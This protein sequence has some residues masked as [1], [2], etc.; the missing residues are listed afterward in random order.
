VDWSYNLLPPEEQS[1]LRRL[2]VFL[3]GWTLEAAE[4]I[5]GDE[6]SS[7]VVASD[8]VLDNLE[9]LINK[10]LVIT[11]DEHGTSRYRMLETIRQYANEK[12]V[13]SGESDALHDKHLEYFLNL[14]ETAA[15]HLIRH[16]QLEW[17]AQLDADYENLRAALEWALG[18]DA[19]ASSLRLCAALGR[20]WY[21]RTILLE[22]SKWLKSALS[23]T[24]P[25]P[26]QAEKVAR[27]K[28][29]YED[30][31][32]AEQLDDLERQKTSAE[33]SFALAREVSG[34]RDNVIARYE[35]AYVLYR[36]GEYEKALPLLEQSLTEFQELNELYWELQSYRLLSDILVDHGELKSTEKT[37][38]DLELAR[39][40]GERL[41]F[42]N[43]LLNYSYMLFDF[44][45]IDEARGYA[46]EA[47]ILFHQIGSN[48]SSTSFLFA[49]IARVN[50]DYEEAKSFYIEMKERFGLLG[51]KSLR[52][53]M[54]L[55]LGF[56]ALEQG[57]LDPAHAYF[58]EALTTSREL[59]YKPHIPIIAACLAGLGN[60][61]YLQGNI[62]KFKGSYRESVFLA[63]ELR[64]H[65]KIHIVVSILQ[66]IYSQLPENSA[67][68]LGVIDNSQR[69]SDLPINPLH[70]RYYNHAE[71]FAHE[72]LGEV[73]FEAAFAE[74]QK[75]SLDDALDL[76]LEIVEEME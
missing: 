12:L 74:G 49:R 60:I 55:E 18:K 10:S 4:S 64:R 53:G 51:E 30:A 27:V 25:N 33:Q 38:Q 66:S 40:A 70:K 73:A 11:K 15:P 68:L 6:S 5:C 63:N 47:D 67:R 57:D 50:G 62:E 59:E 65:W 69:E 8:D 54:I 22:G 14:A 43:A 19:A 23:K 58:K 16:E 20:Y 44:N 9:Q 29:L 7:G 48:M 41:S 35:M 45:R 37:L 26:T 34:K 17:L 72:K 76:V 13:D 56:L 39:K 1:L 3:G 75:M 71:E 28:A 42:A 61:F 31:E 2:A 24:N 46:E 52:T 32:L 21:L 36:R